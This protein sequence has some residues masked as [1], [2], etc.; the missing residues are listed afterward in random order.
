[1]EVLTQKVPYEEKD[2]RSENLEFQAERRANSVLETAV[3]G[4]LWEGVDTGEMGERADGDPR[5][6]YCS[7]KTLTYTV[8]VMGGHVGGL[9]ARRS[10]MI[11]IFKSWPWPL[12]LAQT[13]VGQ[14]RN[15]EMQLEGHCNSSR[16]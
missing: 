11:Y 13:A 8:S 6:G 5:Q 7:A 10:I 14:R 2:E 3:P 16:K 12:W 9:Q 15:L 1:M 4:L